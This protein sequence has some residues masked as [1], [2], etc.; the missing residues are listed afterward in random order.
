[1]HILRIFFGITN[2]A[3]EKVRSE[4]N[5]KVF[6]DISVLSANKNLYCTRIYPYLFV[7]SNFSRFVHCSSHRVIKDD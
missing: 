5:G 2:R 4:D 3:V 7:S 6:D 1:M